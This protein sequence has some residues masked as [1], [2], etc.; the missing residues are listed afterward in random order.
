MLAKG[1]DKDR[2]DLIQTQLLNQCS[3]YP[4]SEKRLAQNDLRLFRVIGKREM[5]KDLNI[6]LSSIRNI[7]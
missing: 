1:K 7:K 3:G 6:F 5:V 2:A 4:L